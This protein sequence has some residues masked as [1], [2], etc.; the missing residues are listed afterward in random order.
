M[1]GIANIV[2]MPDMLALRAGETVG[3][4]GDLSPRAPKM[5][6]FSGDLGG[7]GVLRT[8]PF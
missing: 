3:Y 1:D 4:V 7:P 5:S 2:M 8:G 6:T